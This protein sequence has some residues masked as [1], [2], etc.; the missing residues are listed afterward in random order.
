MPVPRRPETRARWTR[1]GVGLLAALFLA[2]VFF[3]A[4]R[5]LDDLDP[6][7]VVRALREIPSAHLLLAAGL[8][9]LHYL[10][11]GG[12]DTT[13]AR[14]A[15][16]EIDWRRT[17]LASS[18]GH[19]FS[20]ALGFGAVTG[21][22][23]RSRLYGHWGVGAADL[24]RIV[25]GN[26]LT[27]TVGVA[28]WGA[29]LFLAEPYELPA[30]VEYVPRS[31]W[32]AGAVSAALVAGYL[33]LVF[34]RRAPLRILR[35]ELPMPKPR[36]VPAQLAVA[37]LA[38]T[39]N[40]GIA[41]VLL[42]DGSDLGYLGFLEIF[43]FAQVAGLISHVPGGIGVVEGILLVSLAGSVPAAQVVAAFVVYRLFYNVLP[44]VLAL[45]V[46]GGF[47]LRRRRAR[48]APSG[49]GAPRAAARRMGRRAD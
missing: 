27:Y 13:S 30:E 10:V 39:T 9:L 46:V 22:G 8:A 23:A 20:H 41:W 35:F 2:A 7:D 21:S 4:R 48:R 43:L 44:F 16:I 5:A 1:L 49:S 3:G 47:E 37:A 34:A 40:A 12:Y 6:A 11:L 36:E 25:L 38:W 29:V 24:A 28:A 42:R 17:A 15:A 32:P 45:G 31:L 26:A 33:A 18:V 19:A 14:R